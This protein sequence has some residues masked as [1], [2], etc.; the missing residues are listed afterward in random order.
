MATTMTNIEPPSPQTDV[1][2]EQRLQR[3]LKIVVAGLSALIL[4][5]LGAV[6]VKVNGLATGS[7]TGNRGVPSISA[8]WRAAGTVTVEVPK[9]SKVV[10]VSLSGNRLAIHHEGPEGADITILDLGTGR[11]IVDVKPIEAPPKN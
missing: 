3:N 6:I 2:R 8:A 7:V 9:G 4:I 5:G 10:S 11:R 1:M